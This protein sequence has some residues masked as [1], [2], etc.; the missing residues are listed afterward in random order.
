MA[1][2]SRGNS[3]LKSTESPPPPRP[4]PTLHQTFND[5]HQRQIICAEDWT[6]RPDKVTR[7]HAHMRTRCTKRFQSPR[8]SPRGPAHVNA[9]LEVEVH[10]MRDRGAEPALHVFSYI[11]VAAARKREKILAERG[12]KD[13]NIQYPTTLLPGRRTRFFQQSPASSEGTPTTSAVYLPGGN[14]VAAVALPS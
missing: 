5:R 14:T 3:G 8:P 11:V 6:R 13:K 12:H 1:N 7:T 9:A 4:K 10:Y 2:L